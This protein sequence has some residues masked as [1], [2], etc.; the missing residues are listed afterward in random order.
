MK[1][2][3]ILGSTGSIG[4]QALDIIKRNTDRFAVTALSCGE[5]I[6]LLRRQMDIFSPSLVSV[7]HEK[8]AIRLQNRYPGTDVLFGKGGLITIAGDADYDIMLNGLSG[9]LGMMPTYAAINAGKDVALAN[10]ESLV[11]GGEQIIKAAREK[12]VMILPVDSEH[13]A[14]FQALGGN[15]HQSIRRILLTASGGPFRGYTLKQLKNVGVDEALKHPNWDMGRKIS[16]DSATM[17]NKG[18]EVIE[19]RWLFDVDPDRIEVLIHKQS[20]IHSMVEYEDRSIIAQLGM[21][22]MRMPIAYAF[23]WPERLQNDIPQVDFTDL[24][25]LTFEAPDMGTFRCLS[26]AYDSL[27]AGGS[28]P[29]VLN[30]ANEVMVQRFLERKVSFLDIPDAIEHMLKE[31]TP[32]YDCDLETVVAVDKETRERLKQ[33]G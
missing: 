15:P 20:I 3:A 2:I 4:T 31:H 6:D 30:A 26:L 11:A 9:I 32:I 13:S 14:I 12:G 17:M 16:V 8:D 7:Q 25:C 27:K 19:A 28:Y 23:T 29:I 33:W 21:P 24:K 1:K 18:L 22:D 10:K 5:N